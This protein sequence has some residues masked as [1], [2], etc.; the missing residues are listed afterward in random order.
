MASVKTAELP[1]RAS[2]M[3]AERVDLLYAKVLDEIDERDFT[4]DDFIDIGQRLEELVLQTYPDIT[5]EQQKSLVLKVLRRT[6]DF[7]LPKIENE[8]TKIVIKSLLVVASGLF[9]TIRKA[10]LKQFD[11]DGDGEISPAECHAVCCKRCM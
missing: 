9:D 7:V 3:L 8:A 1:D 2:S 6:A 11:L 4:G 5:P 10:L